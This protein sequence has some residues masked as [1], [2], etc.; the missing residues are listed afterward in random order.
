MRCSRLLEPTQLGPGL[1]RGGVQVSGA[2]LPVRSPKILDVIVLPLLL[3]PASHSKTD[4]AASVQAGRLDHP[5]MRLR[6]G[7]P[8]GPHWAVTGTRLG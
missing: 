2:P 6:Y 1:R 7:R 3:T 5:G 4:V 8:L